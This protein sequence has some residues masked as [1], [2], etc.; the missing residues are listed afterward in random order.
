MFRGGS[1]DLFDHSLNAQYSSSV[2]FRRPDKQ[3]TRGD[4]SALQSIPSHCFPR[5]AKPIHH[6]RWRAAARTLEEVAE[7]GGEHALP[8]TSTHPP[9]IPPAG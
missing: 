1:A 4:V 6:G 9:S 7:G 3:Q 2:F 5:R 8:S